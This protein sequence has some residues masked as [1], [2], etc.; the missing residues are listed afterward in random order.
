MERKLN[1]TPVP[2]DEK[3]DEPSEKKSE[4]NPSVTAAANQ[5]TPVAAFEVPDPIKP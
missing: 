2:K 3:L 1:A 4:A 5:G